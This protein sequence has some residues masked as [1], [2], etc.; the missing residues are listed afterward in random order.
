MEES[1]QLEMSDTG[2]IVEPTNIGSEDTLAIEAVNLKSLTK[3]ELIELITNTRKALEDT[4]EEADANKI[5]HGKQINDI[6]EYYKGQLHMKDLQL[7]YKD[8]KFKMIKDIIQ[9]EGEIE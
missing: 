9:L 4:M 2:E 3:D 8:R 5:M 7:G 6:N 1:V